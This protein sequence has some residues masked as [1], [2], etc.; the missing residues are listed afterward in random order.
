MSG[1]ITET[2][3]APVP[4]ACVEAVPVIGGVYSTDYVESV[5][6]R[7]GKFLLT[8]LA[9]GRYH[10]R[11]GTAWCSDGPVNLDTLWY[12]EASGKPKGTTVT[13]RAGH[14]QSGLDAVLRPDG[15]IT[16]TVTGPANALVTGICVSA[17]PVSRYQS[18]EYAVTNNGSYTLADLA[19]G[20]YR[21]EF[22]PGCGLTGLAT[23]WWQGVASRAAAKV[24]TVGPGGVITGIDATMKA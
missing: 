23:Q 15:T 2:G 8:G 17:V 18:T 16:G 9:P 22:Q 3:G 20:R 21:V 1:H 13:V 5:T 6:G 14:V 24:I 11:V 10:V 7:F 19:P 4:G 12:G